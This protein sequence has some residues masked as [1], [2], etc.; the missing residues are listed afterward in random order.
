[1][2]KHHTKSSG[3]TRL[4]LT[5]SEFERNSLSVFFKRSLWDIVNNHLKDPP[6]GDTSGCF[7]Q[8]VPCVDKALKFSLTKTGA[9]VDKVNLYNL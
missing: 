1:M 7:L 2:W 6:P 3:V 5:G 8:L 9:K 4:S